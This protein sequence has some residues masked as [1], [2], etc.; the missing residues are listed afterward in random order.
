M[1]IAV[2]PSC[3]TDPTQIPRGSS[4]PGYLREWREYKKI[5]WFRVERDKFVIILVLNHSA[6]QTRY[7]FRRLL[8]KYEV[9]RLPHIAALEY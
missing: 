1:G 7:N 4:K 2:L 8:F 6:V 9:L 3:I 5:N